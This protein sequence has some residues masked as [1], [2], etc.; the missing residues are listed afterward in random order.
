MPTQSENSIQ[1]LLEKDVTTDDDVCSVFG[2]HKRTIQRWIRLREI[3][4]PARKIGNTNYWTRSQW[5]THFGLE[6][7]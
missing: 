4:Q 2:K 5:R 3:P 7:A 6:L 1:R